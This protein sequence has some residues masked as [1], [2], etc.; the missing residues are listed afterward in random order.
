MNFGKIVVSPVDLEPFDVEL[1]QPLTKLG[2]HPKGNDVVVTDQEVSRYHC[3]LISKDGQVFIRDKDSVNGTS[4]ND[5]PCKAHVE[6]PLQEGFVITVGDSTI[7]YHAPEPVAVVVEKKE[8]ETKPPSQVRK[9]RQWAQPNVKK[10]FGFEPR[11]L[12]KPRQEAPQSAMV[13]DRSKSSI[14]VPKSARMHKRKSSEADLGRVPQSMHKNQSRMSLDPPP[15]RHA[16]RPPPTSV[17]GGKGCLAKIKQIERNREQR[18]NNQIRQAKQKRE[19]K[20]ANAAIGGDVDFMQMIYEW[21]QEHSDRLMIPAYPVGQKPLDN[22]PGI[23]SPQAG[24]SLDDQIRV[25]VRK[26]PLTSLEWKDDVSKLDIVSCCTADMQH[27]FQQCNLHEPKNKVDLSKYLSNHPFDFDQVFHEHCTNAQ[28]YKLTA[29]PLVQYIFQRGRATCFAYGQTGS[30]KTYTMGGDPASPKHSGIYHLVAKDVFHNVAKVPGLRVFVSYFEI[31]GG[32]VYDLLNSRQQLKVLED[33]RQSVKVVGLREEECVSAEDVNHFIETGSADRAQGCTSANERSSR[34]HG[35]FQIF[36]R[37]PDGTLHGKLSLVDLAGSERGADTSA[38][39]RKTRI[40]GAEIN[41]SLLALKECIRAMHSKASHTPFRA[42]K[43]TQVLKDSFTNRNSRTVM[44]A[45]ISPSGRNAEHT[46]NTLRY[47]ARVK[48]MDSASVPV[49]QEHDIVAAEEDI[50]DDNGPLNQYDENQDI[51]MMHNSLNEARHLKQDIRRKQAAGGSNNNDDNGD[52]LHNN[53]Q[54][55]M[56]MDDD[57]E[58]EEDDELIELNLEQQKVASKAVQ[59]EEEI[60]FLHQDMVGEEQKYLQASESLLNRR[61]N[62]DLDPMEYVEEMKGMAGSLQE[63]LN[64]LNSALSVY[65]QCLDAEE[66]I[67]SKLQ[68]SGHREGKRKGGFFS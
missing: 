39:D 12:E 13:H 3:E 17:K 7:Q 11:V 14:D 56:M 23:K 64:R 27:P 48:D 6:Y 62:G 9:P 28:I 30:G 52:E 44:I 26:R 8:P 41:K 50:I 19:L 16:K 21:R 40:E 36:L 43:L 57:E 24:T 45:T 4:L 58:E 29:F 37:H 67:H 55:P 42:S 32:H 34:S 22:D 66:E 51:D 31:Y 18:R 60:L 20:A 54:Q 47:A 15:S 33:A 10:G 65:Q 53:R 38:A 63:R 49:I 46:L 2:R 68:R 61:R 1:S 59:A 35:I 5:E 25:C